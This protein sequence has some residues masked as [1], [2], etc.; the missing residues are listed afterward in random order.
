MERQ[1]AVAL[2]HRDNLSRGQMRRHLGYEAYHWRIASMPEGTQAECAVFDATDASRINPVTWRMD[3]PNMDWWFR[4]EINV[5]PA[6]STKLLGFIV[7][8]A[9]P[10]EV[11]STGLKDFFRQVPLPVKNTHPQQSCV[12]W[13]V[14][15]MLALQRKGWAWAFDIDQFKAWALEYADESLE[16]PDSKEKRVIYPNAEKQ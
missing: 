7:I 13:A 12:T 14:D 4:A 10:A 8:G 3:N 15:A 11:S 6:A 1:I 16:N 2:D 9:V 5:D